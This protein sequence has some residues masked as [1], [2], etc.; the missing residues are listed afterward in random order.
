MALRGR[1]HPTTNITNE[2]LSRGALKVRIG[3][4]KLYRTLKRHNL[5]KCAQIWKNRIQSLKNINFQIFSLDIPK[6]D[7]GQIFVNLSDFH[8]LYFFDFNEM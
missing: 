6:V 8:F 1:F 5:S 2:T 3:P 7:R 4:R